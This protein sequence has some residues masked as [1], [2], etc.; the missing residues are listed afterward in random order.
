VPRA[1]ALEYLADCSALVHPS[2]HDS[3]GWVCVEALAAGRP[4]ICLDWGGPQLIVTSECG[5]KI[6]TGAPEAVV[7]ALADSFSRLASDTELYLCLSQGARLRASE[8]F[9]WQR[10]CGSI[11]QQYESV[12]ALEPAAPPADVRAATKA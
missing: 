6:P 3:G 4:V 9:R 8:S 12:A 10:T 2:L 7:A 5:V 1:R 11:I